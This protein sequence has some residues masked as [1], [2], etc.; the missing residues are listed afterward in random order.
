MVQ[1][2]PNQPIGTYGQIKPNNQAYAN[3]GMPNQAYGAGVPNKRI[4]S[5]GTPIKY[6]ANTGMPTTTYGGAGNGDVAVNGELPVSGMTSVT[7]HVPL[8]GK[9]AFNGNVACG[10]TVTISG[11]CAPRGSSAQ[12]TK[13]PGYG[14]V[15]NKPYGY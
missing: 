8:T 7:G 2:G 3:A 4:V 13:L 1:I 9:V 10:G 6:N 11:S 14:N 15:A 12:S 5:N